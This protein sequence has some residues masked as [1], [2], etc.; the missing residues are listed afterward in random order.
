MPMISGSLSAIFCEVLFGFSYL[1]TKRITD[2]ISPMTLLSWRFIIAFLFF[3]ICM[4]AGIIKVDFKNK[5][6]S[7]LFFSGNLSTG[8][9][10]Y[11]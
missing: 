6:I 4:L 10:F 5:S 11:W 9:I 8:F 2:S 3:N 7:P 1:F